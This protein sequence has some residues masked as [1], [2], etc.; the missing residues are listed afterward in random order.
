MV[1]M[2]IGIGG[3]AFNTF[4]SGGWGSR[5]MNGLFEGNH[6]LLIGFVALAAIILGWLS[7]TGKLVVGNKQSALYDVPVYALVLAGIYFTITWLRA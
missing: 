4:K 5:L 6:G 7:L 1:M 2:L 3:L